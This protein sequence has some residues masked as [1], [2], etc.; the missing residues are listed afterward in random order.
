MRQYIIIQQSS[1]SIIFLR[2]T[3]DKIIKIALL[4]LILI[5]CYENDDIRIE[6]PKSEVKLMNLF[7]QS[8]NTPDNVEGVKIVVKHLDKDVETKTYDFKFDNSEIVIPD[9]PIGL[10]EFTAISYGGEENIMPK[11]KW[12]VHKLFKNTSYGK[13]TEV[14]PKGVKD[15]HKWISNK[16]PVYG[17]YTGTKQKEIH[18]GNNDVHFHMKPINGRLSIVFVYKQNKN[19]YIMVEHEPLQWSFYT[20]NEGTF[21]TIINGEDTEEKIYK[22][23]VTY[24]G[25][26]YKVK[27]KEVLYEPGK[28]KTV[29]FDLK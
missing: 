12:N 28:N 8:Q 20:Y 9:I 18:P 17:K 5:S 15:Y 26:S 23:R 10:N 29:V 2:Y 4:S 16:F 7:A 1:D 11:K 14:I 3:M 13:Y 6:H 22:F 19:P 24:Q 21:A 27:T 25:T